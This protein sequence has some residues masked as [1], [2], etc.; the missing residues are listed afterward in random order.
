VNDTMA[1]DG[2]LR[3]CDDAPMALLILLFLSDSC[4]LLRAAC[5]VLVLVLVLVIS[6]VMGLCSP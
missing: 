4:A 1:R 3:A 5:C 6:R 2:P